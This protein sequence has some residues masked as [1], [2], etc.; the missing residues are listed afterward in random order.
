MKPLAI[1]SIGMLVAFGALAG[2]TSATRDT[3][4]V[5]VAVDNSFFMQG[6]GA[7]V[8]AELDRIDDRD[9]AEFA[10][11]TVARSGGE[12]HG[13]RDELGSVD[14]EAAGPCSF[15][16]IDGF[17]DASSADEKILVTSVDSCD[18]SA[19]DGWT[20]IEIDG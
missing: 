17:A 9:Y 14:D 1:W 13:Y 18:T 5:F 11:V 12:V 3:E 8:S 2:V 19:L 20:I 4:Q 16:D 6:R 15:D 10:L 7:R